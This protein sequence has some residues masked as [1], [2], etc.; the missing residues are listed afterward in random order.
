[1]YGTVADLSDRL[2]ET[3]TDGTP[4]Y[5]RASAALSDASDLIE[6]EVGQAW[7]DPTI[8]PK[9]VR[10]IALRAAERAFRNPDA[11]TYQGAGAFTQGYAQNVAKGVFL[12]ED[13]K[14]LLASL[15]V[16]GTE[17]RS[18]VSV[19]MQREWDVEL[20]ALFLQDQFDGES[21]RYGGIN[22]PYLWSGP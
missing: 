6:T 22:D 18:L 7:T 13:E 2:G 16:G 1:M 19:E 8:V 17:D 5:A 20:G 9:V 21:I 14:A 12:S 11:V 15:K 10:V 4:D 3:L